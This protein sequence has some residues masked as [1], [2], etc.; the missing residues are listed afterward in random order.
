M[1]I[2]RNAPL[3][4]EEKGLGLIEAALKHAFAGVEKE[5]L[6]QLKK[7]YRADVKRFYEAMVEASKDPEYTGY[8]EGFQGYSRATTFDYEGAKRAGFAQYTRGVTTWE[9]FRKFQR[10]ISPNYKEAER[11]ARDSYEGARDSFVSKN[12]AKFEN[13]LGG[14]DDVRDVKVSFVYKRGIFEGTVTVELDGA[15]I[16][17]YVSLKYVIRTVPRVTPYYQYPLLF[18]S[19]SIDGTRHKAPSEE[20]LRVLLGGATTEEV[21]AQAAARRSA[22]GW[23]PGSGLEVPSE[24]WNKIYNMY[25]KSAR[26]TVCGAGVAVPHGKFRKHKTPTASKAEA[27]K[28]VS[29][30]GYCPMGRQRVS[31]AVVDAMGPVDGYKDPK[32]ACE[33]CGQPTRLDAQKE[34][35]RDQFLTP[36]G[37]STKMKVTSAKYYRH[38]LG[39]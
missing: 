23:C 36:D 25:I 12:L 13:V 15:S 7:A 32:V 2:R 21:E 19:A 3:E 28:K 39:T 22:E 10:F 14:R 8:I 4:S 29:D 1:I 30:A 18:A 26:C 27:A 31:Q 5:L 33:G 16:L 37:Y 17:A 9:E 20:E 34:W 6:A 35:I 11:N 24:V 38:K